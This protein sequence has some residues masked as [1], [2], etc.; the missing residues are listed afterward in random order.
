MLTQCPACATTFRVTAAQIKAK[1]GRV[2][3]GQCQHAFNALDTLRDALPTHIELPRQLPEKT[4]TIPTI[5][6]I[7]QPEPQ[8]AG[9]LAEPDKLAASEYPIPPGT[10]G[11]EELAAPLFRAKIPSSTVIPPEK[12]GSSTEKTP[13]KETLSAPPLDILLDGTFTHL[14]NPAA[15][16]TWPWIVGCILLLITLGTQ[17]MVAFRTPLAKALPIAQPVIAALC[18]VVPCTTRLPAQADMISIESSDLHP[19]PA[20][21]DH[22][23]VSATLKNRATFSQ[24]FPHLELTL[25]DIADKAILRKVLPPADYLHPLTPIA[26]GMLPNADIVIN[27]VIDIAPLTANGYRLYLFYP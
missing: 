24:Q 15:S 27:L 23:A 12:P 7:N 21:P 25:T 5:E 14:P 16:R 22:L 6:T 20:K 10:T 19:I 26:S 2:R 11:T 17:A 13:T 8:I 3:C 9:G 4:T 1:S 18:R